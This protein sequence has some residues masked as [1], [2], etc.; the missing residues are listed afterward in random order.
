METLLYDGIHHIDMH[1]KLLDEETIL[2]GQYPPGVSDY[3]RIESTVD[4]LRTLTTCYGR[5]YQII[6]IPMPADASGRYPPQ[7][8][9]LTYTNSLIVNKTVLVPTYRLPGDSA[10]LQLY[11]NVMPGYRVMGF[12]CN[13]I[14][15]QL[16]A[17]HCITKEVGVR[18]PVR[19]AHAR[20]WEA[21]D[22]SQF[23]PIE[24]RI[25]VR[26][27]VDS[28]FVWWRADTS[29]PF[30]R[31]AM[32]DSSGV[33]VAHIP[34]QPLG[35]HIAYYID[36]LSHS[37][38]RV[39]KPLTGAAGAFVFEVVPSLPMGVRND[40]KPNEFTL[41]QNYPNPFNPSTKISYQIPAVCHVTLKVFDMLGRE[42]ATLA[43][44][45]RQPGTYTVPFDGSGL[46]SG[47]YF[48]RLEAGGF[49]ASKKLLFLK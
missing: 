25:N 8:D 35:T 48:Y 27:G 37:H 38:R 39:T 49:V 30:T 6:R 34:S 11:R 33:F 16:G 15:G 24:A 10:A 42:E 20:L 41:L 19:I 46:A 1:M 7:S 28:A 45:V 44:E 26:S 22:T 17:I 5:P 29:L 9:Y 4:Y 36:V 14:I 43:N 47:I 40:S 23:Y 32:T 18:E 31:H 13:A 2:V 21:A 12:D 3:S